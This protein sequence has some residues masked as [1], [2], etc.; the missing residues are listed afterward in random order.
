MSYNST[1]FNS[2]KTAWI[3]DLCKL[4]SIDYC[5]IQ[6]H[7]MST[8][9]VDKYIKNQLPDYFPYF[10]PAFIPPTQDCGRAKWGLAQLSLKISNTRI[11]T[12]RFRV[13][14]QILEFP[15]T[16]LLWINTYFPNDPMT[17]ILDDKELIEVLGEIEN[18][19]DS[20]DFDDCI[21]Q[22]DLNWDMSRNTGFSSRMKQF[23]EK[24]GLLSVWEHHPVS[25]THMHTD[26]I[27]TSTL[28]HFLVN[29]RLLSVI[30]E[31]G[32]LHLGDNLSRHSPIMMK[33]DLGK[34][35]LQKRSRT[36]ALRRPA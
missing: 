12:S 24:I 34:L 27:S 2:I 33:L 11:K 20:N 28:D 30:V 16:R 21:L 22:G 18:I 36:A 8:K 15:T 26:L 3:R 25:Y 23:M 13:Q 9:T 7:F 19:L 17:L 4:A 14:A 35:P 29:E 5:S 1:G 10:V 6:E 31:A 32:V